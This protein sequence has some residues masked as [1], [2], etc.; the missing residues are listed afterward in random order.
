VGG[1][2]LDRGMEALRR[3]GQQLRCRRLDLEK[4]ERFS[5]IALALIN[6]AAGCRNCGISIHKII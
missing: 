5:K 6:A 1:A 4:K 2:L 3:R